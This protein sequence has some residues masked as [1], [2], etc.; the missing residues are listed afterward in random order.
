LP[1]MLLPAVPLLLST[2]LPTASLTALMPRP[3]GR[4]RCVVPALCAE[5]GLDSYGAF[6]VALAKMKA[7]MAGGESAETAVS[8][9]LDGLDQMFIPTLASRIDAAP[10]AS[11]ELPQLLEIM[12]ALRLQS[13]SRFE[14]ARDQLQELLG[15]GEINKLDSQ[16]CG[17]IRRDEL[18]AGFL[19]VL[20][21]NLEDAQASD[22]EP[23]IRLLSHLHTRVQEELEKRTEPALALLHKLTRT[24]NQP[25]RGR[26]LRH[27]LTPQTSIQLP[28][29]TDM[30]LNEPAPPQVAPD[31]FAR[32]VEEAITKVLAMPLDRSL[33][34]STV[35]EVRQVAKEARAVV[36]EAYSP[37]ELDSFTEALTPI[38]NRARGQ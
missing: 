22:D 29:G 27:H 15:A 11:D 35:E 36:Q 26:I 13:E 8:A 14:R 37:Q 3:V 31:A 30:P 18:D 7:A 24:D 16:L 10:P 2:P 23:T 25:L 34:E 4:V 5:S 28:D 6:D 20:Y 1:T 9:S 32:A 38:F 33:T 21:K 19:Y 12:S 17:L